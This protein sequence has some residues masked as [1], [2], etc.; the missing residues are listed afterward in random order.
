MEEKRNTN[1]QVMKLIYTVNT[2]MFWQT[3]SSKMDKDIWQTQ[4]NNQEC[5]F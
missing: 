5:L 3:V 2:L 1:V 4:I